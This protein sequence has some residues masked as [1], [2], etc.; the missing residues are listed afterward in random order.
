MTEDPHISEL[1]HGLEGI[2][3]TDAAR[4]HIADR[5]QRHVMQAQPRGR[6]RTPRRAVGAIASVAAAIALVVALG[7]GG[8]S[9]SDTER[10][11]GVG[12]FVG[13]DTAAAR[14]LV[15]VGDVAARTPWRTLRPGEYFHLYASSVPGDTNGIGSPTGYEVW[16]DEDGHGQ[17]LNVMGSADPSR[18]PT[19]SPGGGIGSNTTPPKDRDVS[20]E[21]SLAK[22]NSVNLMG[23][24]AEGEGFQRAWARQAKGFVKTYDSADKSDP[25]DSTATMRP[26]QTMQQFW[27]ITAKRIDELPDEGGAAM[28]AAIAELLDEHL[29][30]SPMRSNRIPSGAW[31]MTVEQNDREERIQFA[32]NILAAA[33]LPPEARR[34]LFRWLAKQPGGT[35][36][37]NA[38]DAIGRP[39]IKITFTNRFEETVPAR[40]VTVQQLVDEAIAGGADLDPDA[41]VTFM[42]FPKTNEEMERRQHEDLEKDLARDH[43]YRVPEHT[44]FRTWTVTMVIDP[45]TGE[46]LQQQLHMAKRASVQVPEL[47]RMEDRLQINQSGG[48]G[49]SEQMSGSSLYHARDIARL[50][51]ARSPV[52]AVA[53]E[54]CTA[55]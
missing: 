49:S 29:D 52:C 48:R 36:A 20:L 16:L 39:G 30:E 26:E 40:T 55:P 34:S 17:V 9:S 8:G 35:F 13:P 19:I 27:S 47:I 32:V 44:E 54:V 15:R 18:L 42:D 11:A 38:T 31:G 53:P 50:D 4:D 10:G 45:D 6:R 21:E 3:P 24:P 37:P 28:D 14:E 25:S 7:P 43:T 5:V 33:P 22:P 46:L 1:R 2:A 12:R 41:R 51:E 23:W